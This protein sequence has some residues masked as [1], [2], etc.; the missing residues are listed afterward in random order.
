MS[1]VYIIC[2]VAPTVGNYSGTGFFYWSTSAFFRRLIKQNNLQAKCALIAIFTVFTVISNLTGVEI[3]HN[4]TLIQTPFLTALPQSDSI[5]NTRTLVI[6]VAGIV[7]GPL[8]GSIVG[9]LG[10]IHRVIQGNFSDFFYIPSSILAGLFT[11]AAGNFLKKKSNLSW[12]MDYCSVG[13]LCRRNS[14]AV[15]WHFQWFGFG[16]SHYCSYDAA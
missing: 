4:N 12:S 6:T 3:T 8:V 1:N 7:G 11:G 2:P 16:A 13:S 5:A 15:Y 9:L 14:D 10:G